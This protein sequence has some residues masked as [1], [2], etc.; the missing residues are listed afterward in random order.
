MTRWKEITDSFRSA[1]E[2]GSIPEG[3]TLPSETELAAEWKVS[4]M[5][6][7][8]AML[9]LQELGL[10]WRK[11]R[12]GTVVTSRRDPADGTG[13]GDIAAARPRESGIRSRTGTIALILDDRHDRLATDYVNSISSS[14]TASSDEFRLL[15][16]N[17]QASPEREAEC[18]EQ[19][20]A[21]ADGILLFPINSYE[22]VAVIDRVLQGGIPVIAL[23]RA[24]NHPGV[25][26]VVS[27]NYGDS[28]RALT[29][30][31]QGRGH[32]R[33]M[34][35]T[36]GPRDT[37]EVSPVIERL[38]AW[39][40]VMQEAGVANPARW[41]LRQYPQN[42]RSDLEHLTLFA[43]DALFSLMHHPE[44]PTAIFCI[45]DYFLI[46]ALAACEELDVRVP[47]Q[48]D[49]LSFNDGIQL[50][51]RQM[52]TVHRLVQRIPQ[53]GRTAT[54]LLLQRI[55]SGAWPAEGQ[56]ESE[57]PTVRVAADFYPIAGVYASEDGDFVPR[58]TVGTP[59]RS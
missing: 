36:W 19:M 21:E 37:P 29:Y 10:V 52:R 26:S 53:I 49:V 44:P 20:R 50:M 16:M 3:A 58:R 4:R 32:Q 47:E 18:L 17:S 45:N 30:L 27:D 42:V 34:H 39:K 31:R 48:L 6:A 2:S 23:D 22:N 51:P 40:Q 28:Y 15:L 12:I 38:D 14:V 9:E 11:R 33:I 54:E 59:D 7:H 24:V 13:G 43:R 57:A 5:T 1:I 56:E 35:F 55:R 8:R 46:A 25:A 41:L